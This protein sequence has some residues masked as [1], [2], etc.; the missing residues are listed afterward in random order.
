MAGEIHYGDLKQKVADDVATFPNDFQQR[1][2]T[3]SDQ[4]V[5][6]YLVAG[7]EEYANKIANTKLLEAQKAFHLR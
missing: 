5:L 4:D 6:D 3:I 1:Y 2:N 7:S